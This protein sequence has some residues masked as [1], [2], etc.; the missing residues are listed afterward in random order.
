M[1]SYRGRGARVIRIRPGE[2][3]VIIGGHKLI[4]RGT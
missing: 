1:Q 4:V 3:I 2:K